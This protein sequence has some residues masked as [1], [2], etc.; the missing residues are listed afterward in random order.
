MPAIVAATG[1]WRNVISTNSSRNAPNC[2]MFSIVVLRWRRKAP[3]PSARGPRVEP[4]RIGRVHPPVGRRLA[5]PRYVRRL[6]PFGAGHHFELHALALRQRLEPVRLNGREV[7]EQLLA[8]L[9]PD[10]T[11]ALGLV[12]PLHQ[13]RKSTRLNSSHR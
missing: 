11:E 10:E 13:D 6:V 2:R 4:P 12:E 7:N 1:L 9:V 5:D 8:R 3:A